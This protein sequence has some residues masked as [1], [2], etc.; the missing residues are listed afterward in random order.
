MGVIEFI[1][2]AVLILGVLA[3][4]GYA[5]FFAVGLVIIQISEARAARYGRAEQTRREEERLVYH[6]RR[7]GV[8]PPEGVS[9]KEWVHRS[10]S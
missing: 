7:K 1:L 6:L 8:I 3:G 2:G 9:H 4:L 10:S 5:I